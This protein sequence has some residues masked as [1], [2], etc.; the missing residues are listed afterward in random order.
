[1]EDIVL[2][3]DIGGSHLTAALV[4]PH[5]GDTVASSYLRIRVN[6]RGTVNEIVDTWTGAINQIYAEV[7][8]IDKRIGFAMPGPFDYDNGISLIQGLNKYDAFY[9]LNIKGMLANKLGIKA[10]NI[11]M[12]N[13]AAS[14]LLGE[15]H[16]GVGKGYKHAIGITLG[17]GT[18]TAIFHE[19][20][21]TNAELGITAF[22]DSIVDE[23]FSTRWFVRRYDEITGKQVKD[24]KELALS[25]DSDPAVREVF[26]EFVVNFAEFL[27]QFSN[28]EKAEVIVLGGNISNCSDLFMN[29]LVLQLKQYQITVPVLI[30]RLGETAAIIGASRLFC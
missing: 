24:V 29:D 8:N 7:A 27:K 26:S 25:Y 11:L 20:T 30:S 17:T 12:M 6:A 21:V 2:G 16:C 9:K 13:D 5:T 3:V 14:F 22:K 10:S 4:N 19:G 1:M 28:T 18:G 23:Y 15:M